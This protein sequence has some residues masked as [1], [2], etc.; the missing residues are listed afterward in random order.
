MPHTDPREL[1]KAPLKEE[2][3]AL[4][5]TL[6]REE[7]LLAVLAS[8]IG[9]VRREHERASQD[10]AAAQAAL[11]AAQ[12]IYNTSETMLRGLEAQHDQVI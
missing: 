1:N 9:T 3:E 12:V 5:V 4:R 8:E 10:L 2:V 7:R 6:S 11:D